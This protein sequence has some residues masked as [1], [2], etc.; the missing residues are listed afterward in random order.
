MSRAEKKMRACIKELDW[1]SR[2]LALAMYSHSG[3]LELK[4]L[5][6]Q[7]AQALR[8]VADAVEKDYGQG[9]A[10]PGPRTTPETNG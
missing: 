5:C 4:V 6:Q 10:T 9:A 3:R 1:P 7:W 8:A 2:D